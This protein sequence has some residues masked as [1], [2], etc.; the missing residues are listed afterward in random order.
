[1][2]KNYSGSDLGQDGNN[3]NTLLAAGVYNQYKVVVCRNY[4][5]E[6]QEEERIIEGETFE[7]AKF[8][9]NNTSLFWRV[10]HAKYF[11]TIS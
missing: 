2:R 11:E 7:R 1:M 4:Y 9:F 6:I 8:G 5:G 3:A 10:V